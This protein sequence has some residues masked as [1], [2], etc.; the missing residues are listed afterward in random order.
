MN[1]ADFKYNGG[2]GNYV[3]LEEYYNQTYNQNK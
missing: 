1:K 2:N 3:T